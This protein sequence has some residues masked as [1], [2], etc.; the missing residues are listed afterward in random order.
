MA[1]AEGVNPST[2]DHLTLA[3]LTLAHL[4]L[5][6]LTLAHLTLAHLTLTHR[7]LAHLAV[8]HRTLAHPSSAHLTLAHV[9]PAH[10]TLAHVT[11]AQT[12]RPN[13]TLTLTH[14]AEAASLCE[15]GCRPGW[16]VWAMAAAEGVDLASYRSDQNKHG[17][18]GVHRNA[19]LS[20]RSYQARMC[21]GRP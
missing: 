1:E 3:H 15:S 14:V 11:L 2:L 4:T 17:F 6:H 19:S 10:R 16:Q 8:A 12:L 13:L 7:T 18:L 5:A 20:L 21:V 9:T